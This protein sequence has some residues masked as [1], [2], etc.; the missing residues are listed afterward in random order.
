MGAVDC[1]SHIQ[2]AMIKT[3]Y[4]ISILPPTTTTKTTK[5]ERNMIDGVDEAV[6]MMDSA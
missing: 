2:G 4:T 1:C 6:P 3:H 5:G